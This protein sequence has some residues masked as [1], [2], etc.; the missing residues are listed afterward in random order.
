MKIGREADYAIR[1]VL[2]LALNEQGKKVNAQELS[3]KM[4]VTIGF[5]KRIA[6]T[7]KHKSVLQTIR[8]CNGGYV[9]AKPKNEISALEV[10]EAI[11]GPIEVNACLDMPSICTRNA[12]M[13]CP[14]RERFKQTR[15]LLRN[16]L[17]AISFEQLAVAQPKP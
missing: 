9:L 6:N 14:V 5:V 3:E 10:I 7:L 15:D 1:I 11:E 13:N 12:S 17:Q 8:G 2:Y 4:H 16:D